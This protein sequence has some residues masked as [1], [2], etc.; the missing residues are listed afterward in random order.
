MDET[1]LNLTVPFSEWKLFPTRVRTFRWLMESGAV[2][3][4]V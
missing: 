1:L 4:R 2:L 3:H